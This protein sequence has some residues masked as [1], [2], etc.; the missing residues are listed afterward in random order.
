MQ[1]R[2]NAECVTEMEK[3][4]KRIRISIQRMAMVSSITCLLCFLLVL[5]GLLIYP[6]RSSGGGQILLL[7][8]G[9]VIPALLFFGQ[10]QVNNIRIFFYPSHFSIEFLFIAVP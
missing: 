6:S 10:N 8:K 3:T 9:A 4:V 5:D 7:L 1:R 2:I